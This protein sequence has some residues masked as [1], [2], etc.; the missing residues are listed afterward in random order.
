MTPDGAEMFGL[1]MMALGA[2]MIG[3]WVGMTRKISLARIELDHLHKM[4]ADETKRA[5]DNF[6]EAIRLH[7][8]KYADAE[9]VPC[10]TV[11]GSAPTYPLCP[12]CNGRGMVLFGFYAQLQYDY[13]QYSS[14]P[15]TEPCRS[16][17]GR[18]Y[19]PPFDDATVVTCQC[20][21][22][23]EGCDAR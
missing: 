6:D 15:M 21:A 17:S 7:D 18:G 2:F 5:D 14:E 19:V 13:A 12:V 4:L 16:C 3:H 20:G 10:V 1:A 11:H 22:H 9:D 8:E 23:A